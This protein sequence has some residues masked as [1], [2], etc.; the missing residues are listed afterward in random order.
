MV[1]KILGNFGVRLLSAIMNLMIAIVVSQYV[2]A[3]GKGEQSLVLTMIAIV[4][5]FDN[6]VG[7][8]SIVYLTNK[9]RIREL[10]FSAYL[11]TILVSV[12]CYFI[13][14]YVE[15]VPAKFI[16]SVLILSAISSIVS[17]HSSILLG[18]ENLKSFNLLSFLVPLLTLSALLL[19]FTLN[20]NRTAEAYVYALYL[21]YGVT[22]LISILLIANHVRKDSVF[23]LSSTWSTFKSLFYYGFQ[24]QLAHVFQL[25][26]FRISYFFLERDCGEAE[27]GIYSN[28]VSVIESIW[29]ISTSISLWQY[30]K[31]SNSTDVNYTKNITEQLTK[32]GLLTAF[33]A[34]TVLL[35]IPSEFYS[36]LFGKEFH[37]LNELM[38]YLAPG[39]W[40]FNYALIIGHY[41]SGH[42]KYYV[43]AIASGIGLVITCLAAY[44]FIPTLK[45]QGAA[46]TASLSYFVTSLVVILYFRKEGAN[47]VVFPSIGE[48]KSTLGQLKQ[49]LTKRT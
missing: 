11:W 1:R 3:T 49:Q 13:L 4:T 26:S 23:Q 29:M 19:Q 38:F 6:M 32:Y 18:K 9:L 14:L 7:G 20:W 41:F 31:I 25:L 39:I 22:L 37:G 2:G 5:I 27:V 48:L 21:A 40:V 36:W 15:L 45:I 24:N 33:L 10:F 30:A 17:I 42:G 8:A 43:N 47:F 35:F 44:Y 34:L 16:L 46:I 28:A 12:A